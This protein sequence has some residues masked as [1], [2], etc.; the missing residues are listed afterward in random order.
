MQYVTSHNDDDDDN[1]EQ[2]RKKNIMVV[3]FCHQFVIHSF[4]NHR[5]T[6]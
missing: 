3:D 5:N 1:T 4:K 2:T 6:I